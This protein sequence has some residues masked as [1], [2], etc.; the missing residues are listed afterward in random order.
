[1]K[2][3][4]LS[5]IFLLLILNSVVA[6]SPTKDF[7]AYTDSNKVKIVEAYKHLVDANRELQFELLKARYDQS[8]PKEYIDDLEKGGWNPPPKKEVKP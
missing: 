4:K 2:Y 3:I 5:I 8:I 7:V 6:Q 1:M